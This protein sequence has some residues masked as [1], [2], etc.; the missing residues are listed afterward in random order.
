MLRILA[1]FGILAMSVSATRPSFQTGQAMGEAISAGVS[2]DPDAFAAE[3]SPALTPKVN[4]NPNVHA[5]IAANNAKY[6]FLGRP[7]LNLHVGETTSSTLAGESVSVREK[8]AALEQAELSFADALSRSAFLQ[9]GPLSDIQREGASLMSMKDV[10]AFYASEI[11]AGGLSA[12]R[13]LAGLLSIGALPNGRAALNLVRPMLIRKAA[14]LAK[15]ES[16][17]D[18]TREMAGSLITLISG[19]PFSVQSSD[20]A[21]GSY[22]HTTIVLPAPSRVYGPDSMA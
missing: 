21:T 20:V 10:V 6:S 16:T 7:A 3:M 22:G 19:L 18:D 11:D 17:S 9:R 12:R 15:K 14:Q 8:L 4:E 13:G 5:V 2:S 1:S